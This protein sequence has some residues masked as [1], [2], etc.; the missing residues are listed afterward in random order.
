MFSIIKNGF[1][2]VELIVTAAVLAI[3]ATIALPAFQH[4]MAE[5]EVKATVSKLILAN[6]SAK[7]SA[8]LHHA[9]VVICPS[10]GLAQCE[11]AKWSSGFIVFTDTN[12]NR[13]VDAGESILQ[14]EALGLQYGTLDWKGGLS[15]PSLTFQALS[16]LPIGSNGS[17]YY[18]SFT[19]VPNQKIIMSKM[20]HMRIENPSSC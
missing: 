16:G 3:I 15:L 10:A 18:C 12:K 6:R 7:N 11:P 20:G 5:Q 9:N 13:Q 4:Y 14:T 19:D 17:F 1:T 8:A 2:L